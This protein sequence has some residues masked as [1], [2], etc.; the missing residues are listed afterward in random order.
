MHESAGRLVT[1]RLTGRLT[2]RAAAMAA[3]LAMTACS[4]NSLGG[5]GDVL[6]TV[7]GQP[8]G[9]GQPTQ[10]SVEIRGVNT[11]QQII[12]VA[13]QDGQ[14]G[15]VRYDQNT[16]VVYQQQQYPVTALERGDLAVVHV[17]DVQGTTY[18]SRVD[19]T[20]SVQQRTGTGTGT[21]VQ[22]AGRISRID[23][24]AGTFVLQTQSGNVTASLPYNPPQA[25]SN[26]FHQLRVGHD[27]RLEATMIGTN[28]AEI[29]RFL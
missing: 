27:V 29:Y 19:V 10:V 25:T 11:Q 22:M 8:S 15:S 6:G 14:T 1:G 13:T 26:Y 17:Q 23:H 5:L 24:T 12:Q 2:G 9:A 20:Q 21:L 18:V 3:V 16:V 28:R 7:L 4:G